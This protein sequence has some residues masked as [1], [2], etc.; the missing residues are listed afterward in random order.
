MET[1]I[2]QDL[3]GAPLEDKRR[4]VEH[5]TLEVLRLSRKLGKPV[6]FELR[7]LSYDEVEQVRGLV[8]N[9]NVHMLL[10]GCVSPKLSDM[11]LCEKFSAATPVDAIKALLSPGEIEDLANCIERLTGFRMRVVSEVKNG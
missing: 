8:Q 6:Q 7:G 1:S 11:A 10:L 4:D 9:R 2:L 5:K 3:L